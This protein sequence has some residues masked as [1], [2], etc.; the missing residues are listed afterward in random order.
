MYESNKT[1]QIVFVETLEEALKV[2]SNQP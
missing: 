1:K 2:F